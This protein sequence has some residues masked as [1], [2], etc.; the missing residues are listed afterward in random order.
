MS[1]FRLQNNVPQV[2]VDESRDFQTL[3]RTFDV[4]HGGIM[5]DI[6][7]M[8]NL[9]RPLK[10]NDS[11]LGLYATKV[12]FFTNRDIDASVLRYILSAFPYIVRMK[13]TEAG[14]RLAVATIMRVENVPRRFGTFSIVIDNDNYSITIYTQL[15]IIHKK[16]LLEV[17]KYVIP[18]GYTCKI[19]SARVQ[20]PVQSSINPSDRINNV[21]IKW[22]KSG[23]VRY[24]GGEYDKM[25]GA[26]D[27]NSII[28]S[29]DMI[30][31]NTQGGSNVGQ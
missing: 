1:I 13:G 29:S 3:C 28:P 11:L 26:Y 25:T 23:V 16:D 27:T 15:E 14:I 31:S 5:Y 8:Q 24:S 30:I 21:T 12:G 6:A 9:S 10:I 18:T 4:L 20:N 22:D 7:S 19:S 2:Y 17:L